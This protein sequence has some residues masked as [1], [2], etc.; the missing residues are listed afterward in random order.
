MCFWCFMFLCRYVKLYRM[1]LFSVLFLFDLIYLSLL[2]TM[3]LLFYVGDTLTTTFHYPIL[4]SNFP[5]GIFLGGR[6]AQKYATLT[7]LLVHKLFS[8]MLCQVKIGTWSC[9]FQSYLN[10]RE[11]SPRRILYYSWCHV[12]QVSF[13]MCSTTCFLSYTIASNLYFIC[14]SHFA[15]L[16][17]LIFF[18]SFGNGLTLIRLISSTTVYYISILTS[19]FDS[20]RVL[21]YFPTQFPLH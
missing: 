4:L 20:P 8:V 10:P 11:P 18:F 16:F 19:H 15:P 21:S 17:I 5:L 14:P 3:T 2:Q 6:R 1:K 13:P 9:H 12:I 7:L